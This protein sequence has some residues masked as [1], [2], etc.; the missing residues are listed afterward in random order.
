M[1]T[2]DSQSGPNRPL[3]GDFEGQVGQRNKGGDRG[4][5]QHKGR[6]NALPLTENVKSLSLIDN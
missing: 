4:A 6:E 5:K 1:H 2:S 3:W